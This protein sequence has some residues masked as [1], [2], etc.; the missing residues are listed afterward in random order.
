MPNGKIYKAQGIIRPELT[1]PLLAAL[2][3]PGIE[4]K[5]NDETF[6]DIDFETDADLI[7]ITSMTRNINV[8]YKIADEFKKKKKTVVMGGVHVSFMPEEAIGHCDSVVIGEVE[9][10][11]VELITD[12]RKGRLKKFY[13]S[14]HLHNLKGIPSPRFDLIDTKKYK[15]KLLPV[16]AAR[17]CLY[18]CEFCTVTRFFKGKVRTRPIEDVLNDVRFAR[19]S[20]AKWIFFVDENII[21]D[22]DY[23]KKLFDSL[24]S[25]H[26]KWMGQ[27]TIQI[28]DDPELLKLAIDSG[29]IFL[30]I[31]FESINID[32]LKNLGKR[33]NHIDKYARGIELLS[34]NKII[35]G[36]SFILGFDNDGIEVFQETL[37]FLKDQKISIFDPY[38]LT[39]SPGTR[40]LNRLK[41]EGRITHKDWQMY[42]G[43]DLVFKPKLMTSD[44]LRFHFWMMVKTFYSLP[45]I[46]RRIF[47]TP[48]RNMKIVIYTNMKNWLNL[49]FQKS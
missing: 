9:G 16:Q 36:A 23:A 26:I 20:G 24:K 34:K 4:V 37:D 41:K 44:E 32:N 15:I 33:I 25:L 11:W 31:G 48:F 46:F 14:S 40:L 30:E 3:P 42:G 49:R 17:G 10:Q 39:P 29:C 38:I 19:K 6:E 21:A 7:A 35:I 5:I 45:N 13:R 18:N 2:T 1:L 43:K 8:A 47:H 28:T 12:Y 27:S 22:R